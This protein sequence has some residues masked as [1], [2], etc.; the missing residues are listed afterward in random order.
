MK[1]RKCKKL[2]PEGASF[3]CYCGTKQQTARSG[4]TRGNGQG[5]AFKKGSSWYARWSLPPFIDESGK[6]HY[7]RKVKGG[8]PTKRD[9]LTY[10]AAP[11][12]V[13]PKLPTFADYYKT[14]SAS[15]LPKLSRSKRDSYRVA[16][17]RLH[18]IADKPVQSVTIAQLQAVVDTE[19]STYYPARSIHDLLSQIYKMAVAEGV[20]VNNLAQFITLPKLEAEETKPFTQEEIKSLWAAYSSG[21]SFVGYILLMIYSGMMPGELLRLEKRMIDLQRQEIRGAGLK[22]KKRKETPI[23]FPSFLVPVVSELCKKADGEK[24][25]NVSES[26]F[27]NRFKKTLLELGLRDLSPYS[28]RHTTATALALG[29][30]APSVIQEVMRHSTFSTTQKYIHPDYSAQHDAINTLN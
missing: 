7:P 1:C 3:C 23:V 5:T 15:Y 11:P 14:L 9:A 29:N 27:R 6:V 12:E 16:W 24:I 18:A 17:G 30:V 8:F 20:A 13:Q 25:L 28:C 19:C 26:T 22:T 2:L 21:K 10:A 4:R